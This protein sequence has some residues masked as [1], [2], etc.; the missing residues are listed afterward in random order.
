MPAGSG[1]S[2]LPLVSSVGRAGPSVPARVRLPQAA[3]SPAVAG[4]QGRLR[5]EAEL[6][7]SQKLGLSFQGSQMGLLSYSHAFPIPFLVSSYKGKRDPLQ[8][9]CCSSPVPAN[10]CHSLFPP[11]PQ[12][13]LCFSSS[14]SASESSFS[15][16]T[17]HRCCPVPRLAPS[18]LR[19]QTAP[20]VLVTAS[21]E[22]PVGKT[23]MKSITSR[24][25]KKERK[26]RGKIKR[27]GIGSRKANFFLCLKCPDFVTGLQK[28]CK[29]MDSA[30][31][32]AG[33]GRGGVS[34]LPSPCCSPGGFMHVC[35]RVHVRLNPSRFNLFSKRD[36]QRGRKAHGRE[37]AL[38][39][40]PV[41]RVPAHH[42]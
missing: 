3:L 17:P 5:N 20:S 21:K 36:Q 10:P 29:C 39:A 18:L 23:G 27:L 38:R 40:G 30:H 26:K 24:R 34:S 2:L 1:A 7:N 9:P 22:E 35:T 33:G 4:V 6:R 41:A 19:Q 28:W 16:V 13:W 31:C 15:I 42:W 25:K 12:L 32:R 11:H 8:T 14:Q 37:Q